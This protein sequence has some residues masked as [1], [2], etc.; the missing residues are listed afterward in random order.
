VELGLLKSKIKL[1]QSGD[2]KVFDG[3]ILLVLICAIP[4]SIANEG[5]VSGNIIGVDWPDPDIH[6]SATLVPWVTIENTGA[7]TSFNIKFSI[8]G[9]DDKWYHGACSSTGVL[10]H[11]EK[12]TVWP[13]SVQITSSMPKGVVGLQ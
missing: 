6:A 5:A 11:G 7:P 12:K 10:R 3:L 8:Q 2:M 9:P 1:G 13:S 4:L